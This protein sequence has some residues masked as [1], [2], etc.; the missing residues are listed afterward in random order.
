MAC[1][2]ARP[3]NRDRDRGTMIPALF[4]Q[5]EVRPSS[6]KNLTVE[7][8]QMLIAQQTLD[9]EVAKFQWQQIAMLAGVLVLLGVIKIEKVK[10]F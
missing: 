1:G 6:L 4:F 9:L 5:P 2:E 8:K 7:E 10:L 3:R